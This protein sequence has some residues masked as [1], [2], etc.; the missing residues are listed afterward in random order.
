MFS[1][2]GDKTV[3]VW[4]VEFAKQVSP[5]NGKVVIASEELE[6]D[7][8]KSIKAGRVDGKWIEA[9]WKKQKVTIK[10]RMTILKQKKKNS[11]DWKK[12]TI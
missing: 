8:E 2:S 1:A 4:D 3:R 6:A 7:A 11:K 12:E 9:H 10:M 5:V